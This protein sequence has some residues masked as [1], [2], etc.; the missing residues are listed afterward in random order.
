MTNSKSAGESRR[1]RRLVFV[2]LLVLTTGAV[3]RVGRRAWSVERSVEFAKPDAEMA[4]EVLRN[5]SGANAVLCSAA[6]RVF[7]TGNW[8]MTSV[9]EEDSATEELVSWMSKGH[10]DAAAVD[11]AKRSFASTDLCTRRIA[12]Q[13]AGRSD[14]QPLVNV[15][16]SELESSDVNVR[17][18]AV[19]A[20]GIDGE[21]TSLSRLT[22]MLKDGDRNVRMN[23][24]WALGRVGD[25]S[26]SE[27]LIQLLKSDPDAGIRRLAAYAL[28]QIHG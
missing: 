7:Q 26:S 5:V 6:E 1:S 12:A 8:G 11:V 21:S 18:A 28:G 10:V 22:Q 25:D 9:I 4:A 16:R 3:A 20:L 15:L 19:R 23:A 14:V 2:L 27:V 24:V 13:I 17:I